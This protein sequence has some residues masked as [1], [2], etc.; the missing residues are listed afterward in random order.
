MIQKL[1]LY[2]FIFLFCRSVAQE[3]VFKQFTVRDGLP[4]N[5]VHFAF[6]DSKGYMWFCTDAGI[7]KYDANRFKVFTTANG[8]PDN[9]V[10]EL[11]E[12]NKGRIWFRTV[13]NHVGY[14]LNDSVYAI[15]AAPVIDEFAKDGKII[16]MA[17]S[18]DG[19]LYLGRQSS[20]PSGFLQLKEPYNANNVKALNN[21]I[22]NQCGISVLLLNNNHVVFTEARNSTYGLKY[23][24]HILD[25]KL[26]LIMKDSLLHPETLPN[27][28]FY[29]DRNQLYYTNF[30]NVIQYDLSS[31]RIRRNKEEFT[32]LAVGDFNDSLLLV[33][34]INNGIWLYNKN[35]FIKQAFNSLKNISSTSI[36]HDYQKGLWVSTLE[37][38]VFYFSSNDLVKYVIKNQGEAPVSTMIQSDYNSLMTGHNNGNVSRIS[39]EYSASASQ[40][41]II[42]SNVEIPKEIGPISAIIPITPNKTLVSGIYSIYLL[43]KTK[44]GYAHR[45]I[46]ITK[47]LTNWCRKNNKVILCSRNEVYES[48]TV[49]TEIAHLGHINDRISGVCYDGQTIYVSGL[50]G[51]YVYNTKSKVFEKSDLINTRVEGMVVKGSTIYF[52]TKSNGVIVRS[53]NSIDTLT[54]KNGLISNICRGIKTNDFDVWAI[55]NNG[56]SRIS[57]G[58]KGVYKIYNYFLDYFT[59]LVDI[60]DIILADD[61]LFF[62]SGSSIYILNIGYKIPD[63]K[64]RILGLRANGKSY[65]AKHIEFKDAPS[66]VEVQC[67]ALLYKL[68]GK[69]NYR[70]RLNNGNWR[71]ASQNTILLGEL[72]PGDYLVEVEVLNSATNW[73]KAE[74]NLTISIAKPFWQSPFFVLA[75]IIFIS[76]LIGLILYGLSRRQIRREQLKDQLKMQMIELESKSVRSQMNPHFIFNSL[77]TLHRFILEENYA[78]AESYLIRFSKLLRKLIESSTNDKISLKEEMNVLKGYME[79]EQLRFSKGFKFDMENEVVSSE[80]VY[81]PFMLIQPFIENAL[82]HGLMHKAEDRELNVSFKRLDAFRILCIIDDNG[83][84]RE[85][86]KQYRDP[87]KKKSLAIEFITQRLELLSRVRGVDCYFKV[88]DKKNEKN[89]SL[90]TKVEIILPILN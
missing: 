75:I 58:N 66:E 87:L 22:S 81:I 30:K 33:G 13:S 71:Y 62:A 59:D 5:E 89:E 90:G 3:P 41:R 37:A 85:A 23:S 18:A 51:V 49:F 46:R 47:T 34:S 43:E 55:T 48:D 21:V 38:G 45:K 73:I 54:E 79:I 19:S 14:I 28:H 11:V 61:H 29:L 63:E 24:I 82:W 27:S 2:I 84:G 80:E 17:F 7:A 6:S 53:A 76:T 74:N 39:M 65:F 26:Q 57:E 40:I 68:K 67:E 16:S 72:R 52:A 78:N 36:M 1:I 25:E 70:Y 9:T 12:D 31:K 4:S 83:I 32:S 60:K 64:I 69:I 50:K 44:S 20:L 10:F 35:N 8:M 42:E 77:N 15:A 88:I 86:A 56:L